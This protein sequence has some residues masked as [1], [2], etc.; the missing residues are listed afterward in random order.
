[1]N[2][3]RARE[4]LSKEQYDRYKHSYMKM[5]TSKISEGS[6]CKLNNYAKDLLRDERKM[7]NVIDFSKK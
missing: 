7:R 3:D 1:M 5:M 6:K 2:L 4:K